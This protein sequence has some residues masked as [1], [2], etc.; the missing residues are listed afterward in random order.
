MLLTYTVMGFS[1]S[2]L[3]SPSL[4]TLSSLIQNAEREFGENRRLVYE[5]LNQ[6]QALEALGS[7]WACTRS[8]GSEQSEE[9][10]GSI[11]CV[12]LAARV[13]A[14]F[15]RLDEESLGRYQTQFGGTAEKQ[16][17]AAERGEEYYAIATQYRHT[18]AGEKALWRLVYWLLDR[19]DNFAAAYFI[20]GHLINHTLNSLSGPRLVAATLAFARGKMAERFLGA[21]KILREKTEGFILGGKPFSAK[22]TIGLI[23][24]WAKRQPPNLFAPDEVRHEDGTSRTVS[25]W[26][27]KSARHS[28]MIRALAFSGN[29]KA[30]SRNFDFRFVSQIDMDVLE[31]LPEL[32]DQFR[33]LNLKPGPGGFSVEHRLMQE[34][35]I[36]FRDRAAL[37]EPLSFPT[38]AAIDWA[39]RL[40]RWD[41]SSKMRDRITENFATN[42]SDFCRNFL[43][44]KGAG[45]AR[46]GNPTLLEIH[47]RLCNPK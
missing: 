24:E 19:G 12:S 38:G 3:S 9:T 16:F 43:H 42:K 35:L 11:Q 40:L 28:W 30:F 46:L 39:E 21:R 8:H 27:R 44:L 4:R 5:T 31:N 33:A 14:L 32:F 47:K 13:A 2:A 25:P 37:E 6:L 34:F 23:E 1:G 22:E 15:A 45:F 18:A 17:A 7:S 10:I 41:S 29:V 26:I 36:G 20:D